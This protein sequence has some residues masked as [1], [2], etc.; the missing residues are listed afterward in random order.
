MYGFGNQ[1][2]DPENLA[3]SYLVPRR[4]FMERVFSSQ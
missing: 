4:L 1:G 2:I 3:H